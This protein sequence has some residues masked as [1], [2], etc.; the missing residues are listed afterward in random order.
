MAPGSVFSV[1]KASE[2]DTQVG[3]VLGLYSNAVFRQNTGM[4]VFY[5]LMAFLFFSY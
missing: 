2:N 5:L 3:G 1:L 4:S